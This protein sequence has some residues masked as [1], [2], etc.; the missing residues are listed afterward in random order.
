MILSWKHKFIFIK[1]RKVGGTSIEMA[2]STICGPNDIVTPITPIDEKQRITQGGRCQNYSDSKDDEKK[3][4][5]NIE[6]MPNNKLDKTKIADGKYYNHMPLREVVRLSGCDLNDF[7]VFCVERNPYSKII[8]WANMAFSFEYY[9]IGQDKI[10]DMEEISF[11]I[12]RSLANGSILKLK[13][14]DLY[15]YHSKVVAHVLQNENLQDNFINLLKKLKIGT[16]IT[17][18][19]AK[20]GILANKLDPLDYLSKNHLLKINEFFR[21]EFD[22]FGYKTID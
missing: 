19:H 16:N 20:K 2:L 22:T 18:P 14:I 4:L 17:L 21:E 13:N 15:K 9:K 6:K 8:S 3:Y 5:S 10:A 12:D 1:G 7:F 11:L